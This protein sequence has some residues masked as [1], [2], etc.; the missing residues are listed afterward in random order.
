[1]SSSKQEAQ[2]STHHKGRSLRWRQD[3]QAATCTTHATAVR[4]RADLAEVSLDVTLFTHVRRHP[5]R[6]WQHVAGYSV[7]EESPPASGVGLL[8]G[9]PRPPQTVT[10]HEVDVRGLCQCGAPTPGRI[11]A[12]PLE[13]GYDGRALERVD[14]Q[15]VTGTARHSA[16]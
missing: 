3:A 12:P 6:L 7:R 4:R 13:A 15:L 10:T 5:Y 14:G 9:S 16:T 1:M 8:P 2:R 11:P